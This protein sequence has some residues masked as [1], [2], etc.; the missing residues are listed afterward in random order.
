MAATLGRYRV[1]APVDVA[2]HEAKL[3]LAIF[4][5]RVWV[6]AHFQELRRRDGSQEQER[7]HPCARRART[8]AATI[9]VFTALDRMHNSLVTNLARLTLTY[10]CS[11][12]SFA[13]CLFTYCPRDLD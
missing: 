9:H 8:A 7:E 4:S 11:V 5:Q 3:C 1:H 10:D 13:L 12:D 2:S 6:L